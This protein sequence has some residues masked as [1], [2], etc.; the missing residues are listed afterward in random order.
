[1]KGLKKYSHQDREKVIREMIPLIKMKFGEDLIALAAQASYARN[2]DFDYSDLEL[3]AFVR[4]MPKGKKMGAMGKICNGLQVELVW[5]TKEAYIEHT[6]EVTEDWYMAGSDRLLPII[7]APFIE[8]LNS[9][10]TENLKERCLDHATAHWYEVRESTAKVLN[11]ISKN[12]ELGISLLVFDM[13][14]HMLRV[15]SFLNQIPYRTFGDFIAQSKIFKTKPEHFDKL[16]QIIVEGTYQNLA[17]LKE[18]VEQVF[19]EFENLFEELGLDLY[20]DN[21]DPNR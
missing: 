2:E 5:M 7:N 10:K 11:A 14:L 4:K 8:T 20:D 13:Y 9:H 21:V 1:M 6:K 12:N 17:R 16:T 15:L 18:I 3:V 19:S